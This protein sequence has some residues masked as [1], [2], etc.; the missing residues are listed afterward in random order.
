MSGTVIAG[1]RMAAR[2]RPAGLVQVGGA[3]CAVGAI[4]LAVGA[5]I[6]QIVQASTTVSDQL[7][8]YPWSSGASIVAGSVWAVGQA[9]LV[10]GLLALR[11]SGVAGRSRP[12]RIGFPVAVAG[13]ALIIVGHLASMPIRNDNIHRAAAETVA[14]VFGAATILSAVGL[15]LIGSA[16]LRAG[17]WGGWRRFVPLFAGVWTVALIGMQLTEA[18]PTAVAVYS[19]CFALLGFALAVAPRGH[20]VAARA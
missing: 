10:A 9:T 12:A 18:L 20:S 2:P 7:W 17:V 5:V 3:A 4:V 13:T 15:L 16:T 14:G 8:R 6:T 1:A 11:A 19:V